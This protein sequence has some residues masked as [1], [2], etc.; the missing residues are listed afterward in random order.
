MT[1]T[2]GVVH[3]VHGKVELRFTFGIEVFKSM[4]M[5]IIQ[6]VYEHCIVGK[7]HAWVS[8]FLHKK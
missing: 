7:N 6:K 3:K 4:Y 1:S 2:V 8:N 5:K